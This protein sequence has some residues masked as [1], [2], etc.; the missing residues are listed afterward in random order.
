MVNAESLIITILLKKGFI[1]KELQYYYNISCKYPSKRYYYYNILNIKKLLKS[2]MEI[3]KVNKMLLENMLTLDANLYKKVKTNKNNKLSL[4]KKYKI[5]KNKG[6][7][8]NTNTIKKNIIKTTNNTTNIFAKSFSI[9]VKTSIK[10][11]TKMEE[12]NIIPTI[13]KPKPQIQETQSQL[14]IRTL[15][16]NTIIPDFDDN[17]K[18]FHYRSKS[19][20]FVKDSLEQIRLFN[21]FDPPNSITMTPIHYSTGKIDSHNLFGIRRRNKNDELKIIPF[22]TTELKENAL[23]DHPVRS[24]RRFSKFN[25]PYNLKM[26]FSFGDPISPSPLSKS[27]TVSSPSDTKPSQAQSPIAQTPQTPTTLTTTLHSNY[28]LSTNDNDMNT[29]KTIVSST[30]LPSPPPSPKPLSKHSRSPILSN[31]NYKYTAENLETINFVKEKSVL[32]NTSLLSV[33]QNEMTSLAQ[34]V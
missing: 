31:N 24:H 8:K 20:T 21:M 17:E 10:T 25:M 28:K 23:Y 13:I 22:T 30:P 9:P 2:N 33:T 27:M 15:S 29:P 19:V 5:I 1:K 11:E 26:D 12:K 32:Y 34:V 6:N 4:N 18:I 7:I 16:S 3:Q 14:H